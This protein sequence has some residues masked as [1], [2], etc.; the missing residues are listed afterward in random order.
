M[1]V[2]DLIEHVEG[3]VRDNS[4]SAGRL[5]EDIRLALDSAMDT[6]LMLAVLLQGIVQTLRDKL[7]VDEQRQTAIMLC[8]VLWDRISGDTPISVRR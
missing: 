7:P 2:A 3:S 4:L 1:A 5:V 8:G 6:D